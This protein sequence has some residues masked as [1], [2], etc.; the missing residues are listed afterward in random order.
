MSPVHRIVDPFSGI[1][2][3]VH[4]FLRC[5]E[6]AGYEAFLVGGAVRDALLGRQLHD[7]DV[8]TSARPDACAA[9]F[10]E[11]V[12]SRAGA[13]FG[14]LGI[15]YEQTYFEV[16]SYRGDGAYDGRR[17]ARVQAVRTLEEDL[18][19]RDFS[20]NAM[21]WSEATGLVDPYGGQRDL[22]RHVLRTVGD[23]RVRF[24]EDALRMLRAVRF[25][26]AY[27]LE[28]V[29]ELV[30]AIQKLAPSVSCLSEERI[31]WELDRMVQKESFFQA[32][33]FLSKWG[34]WPTLFPNASEQSPPLSLRIA[35]GRVARWMLLCEATET[36]YLVEKDRALRRS[37]QKLR[38]LPKPTA[39]PAAQTDLRR[40]MGR[41][42][43]DFSA[44]C[45]YLRAWVEGKKA[46]A[47]T[48]GEWTH[49][50][51]LAKRVSNFFYRAR[52]VKKQGL[53]LSQK[54]LA[55]KGADLLQIGY[56]EGK[57]IGETLVALEEAVLSDRVANTKVALLAQARRWNEEKRERSGNQAAHRE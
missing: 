49:A 13:R 5:L 40:L 57:E 8:A 35:E 33:D 39:L 19:R 29:P 41:A 22:Q 36:W 55:I 56:N 3:A 23:P 32:M 37:V 25:S 54:D 50:T 53:A 28:P 7:W 10:G 9:L 48:D 15:L 43:T 52:E 4:R 51:A 38:E 47:E 14:T 30:F 27:A 31:F 17:P 24:S 6:A 26:A 44:Y 11:A 1:P 45:D 12:V 2:S 18:A 16:T 42:G 21:A 34:L 46:A 20:I